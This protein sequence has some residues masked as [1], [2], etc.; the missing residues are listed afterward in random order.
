MI[1]DH[2]AGHW[3]SNLLVRA[4]DEIPGTHTLNEYERA[5]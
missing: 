5:T 3:K 1:D 2:H 4:V